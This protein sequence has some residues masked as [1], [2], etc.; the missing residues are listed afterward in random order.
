MSSDLGEQVKAWEPAIALHVRI[1]FAPVIEVLDGLS[2]LSSIAFSDRGEFWNQMFRQ[3][4][5]WLPITLAG[6]LLLLY[7]LARQLTSPPARRYLRLI[8][9]VIAV[10]GAGLLVHHL[11]RWATLYEGQY[12]MGIG[13]YFLMLAFLAQCALLLTDILEH[14]NN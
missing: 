8:A 4:A 10:I 9:L 12:H 7:P 3:V 13:G 1:L 11:L 6:W 14:G 5:Y 2:T